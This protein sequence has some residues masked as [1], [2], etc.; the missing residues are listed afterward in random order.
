LIL[1]SAAN[2]AY[3]VIRYVSKGSAG[4]HTIV[5]IAF[6]WIVY[7]AT[8]YASVFI[9]LFTL[10]CFLRAQRNVL[11]RALGQGEILEPDVYTA[12]F[13]NASFLVLCSDGLWGLVT[14]REIFR[15][16][17][18]APSLHIACQDLIS[19]ANAAGGPDNI[20]VIIVQSVG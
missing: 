16:I 15:M 3:P 2:R 4:L 5:R 14:E 9:H 8:D 7:I 20:S 18:E 17:V 19:A 12:P 6:C 1:R 11:Y 10:M 13:P